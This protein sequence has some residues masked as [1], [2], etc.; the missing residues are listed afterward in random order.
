MIKSTLSLTIYQ[1]ISPIQSVTCSQMVAHEGKLCRTP[2]LSISHL[3]LLHGND[4]S[5]GAN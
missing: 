1:V 5:G 4:Y 3:F 2:A